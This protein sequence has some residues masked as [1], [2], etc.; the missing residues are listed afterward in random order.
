MEPTV[1]LKVLTPTIVLLNWQ[2]DVDKNDVV[3]AF[4]DL[5]AFLKEASQPVHVIVDIRS[6]PGFPLQTTIAN[7]MN[8]V[9]GHEN[10]A[11]WLVVGENQFAKLIA[12]VLERF[13][14]RGNIQWLDSIEE[15]YIYVGYHDEP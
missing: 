15:A 7:A 6:D 2:H 4:D 8:D 11:E 9:Y 14:R 10:L 13:R 1:S 12:S 5:R 3:Q